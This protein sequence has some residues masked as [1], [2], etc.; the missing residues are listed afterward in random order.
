[1][2]PKRRTGYGVWDITRQVARRLQ[3]ERELVESPAWP[4]QRVLPFTPS[5]RPSA[6]PRPSERPRLAA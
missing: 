5:V 4:L 2:N 3:Q 6:P 1:M